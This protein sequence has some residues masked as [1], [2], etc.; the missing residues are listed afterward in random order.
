MLVLPTLIYG[1]NA[2]PIKQNPSRLFCEYRKTKSKVYIERQK[3][4]NI[5]VVLKE[6]K[7]GGLTLPTSRFI[8]KLQ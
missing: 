4:Q 1:L 3:A 5:Y 8:I 7:I 6:N 2:T